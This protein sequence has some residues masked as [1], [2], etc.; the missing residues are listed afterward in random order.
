MESSNRSLCYSKQWS[1]VWKAAWKGYMADKTNLDG[2]KPK[3]A[4]NKFP[5]VA[6]HQRENRIDKTPTKNRKFVHVGMYFIA[7][8]LLLLFLMMCWYRRQRGW[9]QQSPVLATQSVLRLLDWFSCWAISL[10]NCSC[11]SRHCW[12]EGGWK[13]YSAMLMAR[14]WGWWIHTSDSYI[15]RWYNDFINYECCNLPSTRPQGENMR[16]LAPP[17]GASC[18]W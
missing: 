4:L 1:G 6:L 14:A 10:Y 12:E 7:P 17:G 16:A 11:G 3:T 18:R 8:M 13:Q 15:N 5:E 2:Q 9:S